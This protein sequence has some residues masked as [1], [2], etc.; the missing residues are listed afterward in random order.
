MAREWLGKVLKPHPFNPEVKPG[1]YMFPMNYRLVDRP[2]TK[3]SRLHT[4]AAELWYFFV[5]DAPA[6]GLVVDAGERSIGPAMLFDVPAVRIEGV[7]FSIVLEQQTYYLAPFT[8]LMLKRP[9]VAKHASESGKAMANFAAT[10]GHSALGWHYTKAMWG[11]GE[12]ARWTKELNDDLANLWPQLF[13]SVPKSP[14]RLEDPIPLPDRRAVPP[15]KPKR[16]KGK[17]RKAERRADR[18]RDARADGSSGVARQAADLASSGVPLEGIARA[19]MVS[20][21]EV[22]G[23]LGYDDPRGWSP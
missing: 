7:C 17:P 2:G 14:G 3:T 8:W 4:P 18:A 21:N 6:V 5:H 13:A 15:P 19:L 20:T 9:S 23:L 10:G 22:A 12:Q 11:L 1:V 16:S